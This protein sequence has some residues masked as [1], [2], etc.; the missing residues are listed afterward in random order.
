MA[1][2]IAAL[3][4]SASYAIALF[5]GDEL[6]VKLESKELLQARLEA[7]RVPEKQRQSAIERLFKDAGCTASEQA[8]NKKT[9]NVVC[10]LP[11][12]TAATIIVGAHY[13]YAEEGHGIVDDWSGAALL[14]SLYSA[15]KIAPR[16]HAFQF[17]AFA[18]EEQG[19]VGSQ[20][21][22]KVMS[23]DEK[24]NMRGFVNLECLGV[25]SPKVWASRATAALLDR[26]RETAI[27]IRVP[28][29][30][31]NVDRAGYD[32]SHPFLN[33]NMPVITIHSMTSE[34]WPILHSKCDDLEAIHMDDYEATY[35]LIGFYLAYLD[36][37]LP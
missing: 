25:T 28:I 30:S 8:V 3:F 6:T 34:T 35:R 1:P 2:R 10:T 22:V 12:D 17:V 26:L 32:D 20:H 15:L 19:L 9:A 29:Q 4:L 7:G 27:A 24:Q 14:P 36:L 13:D 18:A 31:V 23:S 5:A 16:R 21:F 11:G 33:K 37:K